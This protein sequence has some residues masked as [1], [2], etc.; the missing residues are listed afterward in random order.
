MGRY[1][2]VWTT[3][4]NYMPGTNGNLNALEFYGFQDVDPYVLTHGDFLT[5]VYKKAFPLVK[6][7]AIG[8]LACIKEKG[9]AAGYYLRLADDILAI[10]LLDNYK[11]VLIWGGDSLIVNNFMDYFEIAEKSQKLILATNEHGYHSLDKLGL[12]WPYKH[13]WS[14]PY[15][16]AAFF[17]PQ[18]KV[19][20][21]KRLVGYHHREGCQLSHMDALNYAVKEEGIQV[22]AVPGEQ[23]VTNVPYVRKLQEAP[24]KRICFERS[25]TL[26]NSFHRKYWNI[27]VCLNYLPVKGAEPYETISRLNK[28]LFNRFYHYFNTQCR[29]KWTEGVEVWDGK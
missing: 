10:D 5:D 29:V 25:S 13:T 26:I 28:L 27:G 9:R 2:I 20:V 22:F 19:A 18:S 11:V 1:A 24:G 6:F 17:V 7:S 23:W 21:L 3:S 15:A 16:D 14:V 12:Q 8:D 4:N